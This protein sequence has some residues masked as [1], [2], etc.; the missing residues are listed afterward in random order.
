MPTKSR[1]A[2]AAVI[3]CSIS[4]FNTPV[5]SD[6]APATHAKALTAFRSDDELKRFLKHMAQLAPRA[7]PTTAMDGALAEPPP[8]PAPAAAVASKDAG[9]SNSITN[10]Q[11]SGVDEGDIVKRHGDT[12]VVLH[13]GRI[14]TISTARGHLHAVDSINA[15]PPGI[16]P[17]GDWYDEML[18]GGDRV[19]VIGYSY[20]RGGTQVN[21]FHIDRDG[22]LRFI[23]AYDLR[24]NDYYS[25]RNYASRLI[26][27]KLIFYSPRYLGWGG[28]D[29]LE[30]LPAF[31]RRTGDPAAPFKRVATASQVYYSPA[32]RDVRI[33]AVHSVMTCD[34]AAPQLDCTGMSVLGP[35]GRTFYVSQHAVYVWAAPYWGETHSHHPSALLYRLPLDGG[36][37]Q[38]IGVRG[39]PTDQ[40]SFREDRDALNVLVRAEGAGDAMWTAEFSSGGIGLLRIPMSEF[41][42]GLDEAGLMHYRRLPNPMSD[43]GGTLQNRFAGDYVLYGLGSGWGSPR[44]GRYELVAAPIH[45]GHVSEFDLPHAIDRIDLMGRD[46]VV[47]GSD[48]HDVVFSAVELGREPALGDRYV[49]NDAAQAETHSHGFFFNAEPDSRNGAMSGMNGVIGLPVARPARAAYRQLFENSAAMIYLRR[50]DGRFRYLGELDARSDGAIDDKCAASCV[51]WYGNARPIFMDGRAFA[52]M[53]YELVEGRLGRGTVQEVDRVNFAPGYTNEPRD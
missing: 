5:A 48:E 50:I 1:I 22:H 38:A 6:A 51:D 28:G 25:S 10:N 29:M 46:A 40:F 14:F 26:G 18:L 41:G 8:P 20:S 4:V 12:L 33:D 30:M 35:A 31:R 11:E 37:P 49:L 24:S 39:G 21:R 15:Y 53:G 27:N 32:L 52:L 47:I 7:M 13:R 43:G 19:A 42:D 2:A 44:G 9:A 45:G 23:D 16:D 36:Q 34:L 3:L 17:S